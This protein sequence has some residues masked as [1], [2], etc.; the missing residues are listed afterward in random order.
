MRVV[1]I[2]FLMILVLASSAM[3]A[4]LTLTQTPAPHTFVPSMTQ[5]SVLN[6]NLTAE[7]GNVPM[8]MF[9]TSMTGTTTISNV[10]L[11]NGPTQ[12]GTFT[13]TYNPGEGW[14][15]VTG[16]VMPGFSMSTLTIPNGT[17]MPFSVKAD[18]TMPGTNVF[19]LTG[20]LAFDASTISG[21]PI[22]TEFKISDT[23]ATPEPATWGVVALGLGILFISFR[24]H[25]RK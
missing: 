13:P 11:W 21:Q 12:I 15:I 8:F 3:G 19:T 10:T 1:T 5:V 7:G 6:F 2:V 4:S 22:S 18:T 20:L 14:N 23:T 24:R 25:T 9:M 17:T 16:F